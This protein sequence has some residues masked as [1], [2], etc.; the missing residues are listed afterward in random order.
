MGIPAEN[1]ARIFNYGFTTKENGHGF[2]LH[3]SANAANEL[4]GSLTA[5]SDGAGRGARF[6]L[7]VPLRKSGAMGHDG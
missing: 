7:D 1:A 3:N 4:G 2:G 5:H 6:T